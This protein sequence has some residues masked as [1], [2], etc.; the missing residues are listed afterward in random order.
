MIK[1]LV[2]LLFDSVPQKHDK[3]LE[4]LLSLVSKCE[5]SS[6]IVAPE[7]FL[8]GFDYENLDSLLDLAPL[9][10]AKLKEASQDR[11]IVTTMLERSDDEIY[12]FAKVFYGGEVVHQRAKAKLFRFG[13]EHKYMS[14]GSFDEVEIIE[15][16]G[17]KLGVV[18]CFELR[19]KELWQRLEGCDIIAVTAWWGEARSQNFASLTNALAIMNQ[20]F[21]VASDS[22]NESCTA[23]SG[24]VDPFGIEVRNGKDEIKSVEFSK[25]RIE[26]MRR[27]MNVGIK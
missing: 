24:I 10:T 11:I 15:V 22:Q 3:N 18:I 19:F 27:Y 26:S 6:L 17:I 5:S 12:N 7:V 20:C 1:H 21:I 2:S 25:K 8:G 14:E 16:A 23:L 9:A 13:D 4:K